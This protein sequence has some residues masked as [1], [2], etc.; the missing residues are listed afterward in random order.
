MAE[1]ELTPEEVKALGLER[2][3]SD[4]EA[5]K[6]GLEQP[7]KFGGASGTWELP[8]PGPLRAIATKFNEGLTKKGSDELVGQLGSR[9]I[10]HKGQ[11]RPEAF[12]SDPG[13]YLRLPDGRE[14]PART[15]EEAQLAYREGERLNQQAAKQHWPKL[16]FLSDL[17]GEIAGDTALA[18]SRMVAPLYQAGAGV[19]R[20]YLGTDS[21][22]SM[23]QAV[24]SGASGLL[25]YGFG[26]LPEATAYLSETPV[27]RAIAESGAG[28]KAGE[29][30]MSAARWPGDALER[31]GVGMGRSVLSGAKGLKAEEALS[32]DAIREA[33]DSGAIVPLGTTKGASQRLDAVRKSVGDEYA[34]IVQELEQNGVQGPEAKALADKWMERYRAE[35][36]EGAANKAVPRQFR[37]EASNV[38]AILRPAPGVEGPATNRLRLSQAEGLKRDLQNQARYGKFE[39]TQL[40]NAK[41]EIASDVR[42]AIEGEVR[43]AAEGGGTASLREV[44]ARF[45]PVKQRLSRLIAADQHAYEEANRLASRNPV[46]F[47]DA[48]AG[49]TGF[50]VGGGG[51]EGI[52]KGGGAALAAHLLRS[53]GPS[54]LAVASRGLGKAAIA[55]I[56]NAPQVFGEFGAIIAGQKT[57]EARAAVAEQLAQQ[58]PAFA[59]MLNGVE[60]KSEPEANATSYP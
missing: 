50:G 17:G 25:G 21:D 2:E 27:A 40:N 24:N 44:A 51:V 18:G 26:K 31:F 54:T 9:L 20:G 59:Q 7:K 14:V 23:D 10:Q 33:M 43:K 53:R 47:Y 12:W 37:K 8:D 1:R 45:E 3:L 49:L 60:N 39:E 5:V 58:Y 41:R 38:E 28:K 4:E 22:K 11:D 36:T 56:E 19:L 52:V 35:W 32:D 13:R 42:G 55:A 16:S 34:N 6:L 48:A 15:T 57:P 29:V 46:S 30:L